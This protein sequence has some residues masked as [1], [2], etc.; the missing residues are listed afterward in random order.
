MPARVDQQHVLIFIST[1]ALHGGA[2]RYRCEV[3]LRGPVLLAPVV[4]F[5]RVIVRG[6]SF[7]VKPHEILRPNRFAFK[8]KNFVWLDHSLLSPI[9]GRCRKALRF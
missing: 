1:V 7:L 9:F 5:R 4:P 2:T 6:H 3:P 8:P